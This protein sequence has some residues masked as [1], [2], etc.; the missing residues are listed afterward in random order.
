[1]VDNGGHFLEQPVMWTGRHEIGVSL[2]GPTLVVNFIPFFLVV[3][4][5]AFMEVIVILINGRKREKG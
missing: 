2:G 1:M 4:V 3:V 5:T